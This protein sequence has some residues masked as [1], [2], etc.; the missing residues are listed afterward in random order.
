VCVHIYIHIHCDFICFETA[1]LIRKRHKE[2][3]V[4]VVLVRVCMYH[5]S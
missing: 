4:C 2:V 5:G 1:L 3:C